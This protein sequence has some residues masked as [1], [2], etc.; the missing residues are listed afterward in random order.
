M[1][2]RVVLYPQRSLIGVDRRYYP[3][4]HLD[5]RFRFVLDTNVLL[6]TMRSNRGASRQ[7]LLAALDRGFDLLLSVPLMIEYEAVLNR[8][9]N[10]TASGVT[11]S[12]IRDILDELAR[13]CILVRLA[14]LWR[15]RLGMQTTTWFW[16]RL[17]T[18]MQMRSLRSISPTFEGSNRYS[19]AMLSVR[20]KP[21][22][23]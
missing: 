20:E 15:P 8:T 9:G 6:A 18:G 14:Y 3:R 19:D 13:V 11:E 22:F 21:W 2:P 4:Y 17:R 12:D 23:S 7:L 5:V 1:F 16:K 10:L